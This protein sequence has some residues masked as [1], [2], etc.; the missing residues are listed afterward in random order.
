MPIET[1]GRVAIITGAGQ[2]CGFGV[3][4][5]FASEGAS[6]V[7]TGRVAEKLDKAKVELAARGAKVVICV[8][9]GSVRANAQRAV[10]SAIDAFGRLDILVNNAQTAKTGVMVEDISDDD[11]KITFG[12]GFFAT[13]YHMQAAFP[14]LKER[15]GA[16]IN[17]GTKVGI[18]AAAGY[19]AYGANKEAI[20]ALSRVSAKEWGRYKIRVNVLNPGALSSVLPH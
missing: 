19:G 7:I 10:Q 3:A 20:R 9:D 12:S 18:L 5:V 14:H 8:G 2:G 13:L 11:L 17:F 6:L 15:G 16:I 4:Q 1:A